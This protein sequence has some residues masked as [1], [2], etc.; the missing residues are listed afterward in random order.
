MDIRSSATPLRNPATGTGTDNIIVVEGAGM[1]IDA[2]GGHT[3]MGELMARAVYE[4][5][6]QAVHRQNGLK[7]NRSVFQRLKER[8]ISLHDICRRLAAKEKA[9][10]IRRQMETLLLLPEYAGFLTSLMGVS[11]A[12][13]AGLIDDL[14][15][16]D[17]WCQTIA[18][19][20]AS[21]EVE[22]N[23]NQFDDL[24]TVMAKGFGAMLTG[25]LVK[26]N[27]K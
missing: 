16:V 22:L 12:Y 27:K 23:S 5:V 4:G 20:I 3:K 2:S 14:S 8:K 10:T 11:D 15:S 17:L 19:K 26:M 6:Q 7:A 21:R 1:T 9:G 13:E 18:K 25:V 24:P